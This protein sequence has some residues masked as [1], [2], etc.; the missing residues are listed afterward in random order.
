MIWDSGVSTS[1]PIMFPTFVLS[2]LN[3]PYSSRT[4]PS[5]RAVKLTTASFDSAEQF[6]GN[7]FDVLLARAPETKIDR[8]EVPDGFGALV[9]DTY[10]CDDEGRAYQKLRDFAQSRRLILLASDAPLFHRINNAFGE[11]PNAEIISRENEAP[12]EWLES[13][14]PTG[15]FRDSAG[16]RVW[17]AIRQTLDSHKTPIEN[18]SS[19]NMSIGMGQKSMSI[20]TGAMPMNEMPV[21]IGTTYHPNWVRADKGPV[22]AAT[23]FFMLT[24]VRQ[25]TLLTYE[26]RPTEWLSM[27]ISGSVLLVLGCSLIWNYRQRLF[28]R[29]YGLTPHKPGYAEILK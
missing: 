26:R 1:W 24:F 12:G 15:S 11:F 25:P 13:N 17:Q 9:V 19:L 5:K 20:D 27:I 7:W 16:R 2:L 21:L 28:S 10:D 3:Q 4:C 23:P 18:F 29:R 8:L 14:E 6:A 22:Y